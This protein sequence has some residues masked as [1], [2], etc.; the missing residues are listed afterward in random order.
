[1]H[2]TTADLSLDEKKALLASLERD[3]QAAAAKADG[4]KTRLAN[5]KAAAISKNPRTS[6]AYK[7]AVMSL[8][9]LGCD[10]EAIAASG[11]VADLDEKMK[12]YKWTPARRLALKTCLGIV[13]AIA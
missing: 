13:S 12:Q 5:V 6:E 11:S 3:V 10:I 2:A 7:T 1:M 4:P 9:R 8:S